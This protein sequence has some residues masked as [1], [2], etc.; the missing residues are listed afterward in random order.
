VG[1]AP[2]AGATLVKTALAVA[3][4]QVARSAMAQRSESTP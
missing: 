2:F 4:V 1:F 3:V